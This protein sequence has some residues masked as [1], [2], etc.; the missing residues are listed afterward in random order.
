MPLITNQAGLARTGPTALVPA[1]GY[2]RVSTWFEEKISD[3]IQKIAIE[4]AARRR[5][6]VIVDWIIDLDA[7]GR[8]FKRKIMRA[9]E[10]VETG[11]VEGAREIWVW[12]FSRFGRNRHGVAVNLARIEGAGGQLI[13]A[14]EE[15]D[16]TTATGGL[17]RD[18][19][20]AIAQFESN[21]IGETWR[22]THEFRR[23]HGLP[24]TGGPRF[25]YLRQ[26]RLVLDGAV[27]QAEAYEPDPD[28]APALREV[29]EAYA[30]HGATM[31][32]LAQSLNERGLYNPASV[33]HSG[34]SRQALIYYLDS[35]FPAGFLH[36]HRNDITCPVRSRCPRVEEH[37]GF[38]PGAQPSILSDELWAAYRER[39]TQRAQLPPRARVPQYPFSG[40]VRCGLCGGRASA[41]SGS[42]GRRGYGYRCSSRYSGQERNSCPGS[43]V[44][45][46]VVEAEVKRWLGK[47][48]AEVDRR[49][50]GLVIVPKQAAPVD[51]SRRREKIA[52]ELARLQKGLDGASLAHA[53]GDMPRDSYLRVRDDLLSKRGE[54]ETEAAALEAASAP[55]SSKV[56]EVRGAVVRRLLE[57]WDT[58]QV[59]GKRDL[60]AATL[61]EVRLFPPGSDERVV[62]VPR[63]GFVF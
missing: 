37:Y 53:M 18:M 22:E 41:F 40:V 9:I 49:L 51:S 47:A 14:T 4:D 19:L 27:Q 45:A 43:M 12:K 6:R 2:I 11:G 62:C 10:A 54:L 32:E 36:A 16:S 30:D 8:N 63:D 58:L 1:I 33:A 50:N 23:V 15:V 35:G 21:R 48:S 5:G 44:P 24:A 34:W 61:S 56:W 26:Q 31:R 17:T 52:S 20:F 28:T 38:I 59:A 46:H 60:L 25:G 29:Y 57:E 39:R 7:T 42:Q 3:E 55:E 13:S